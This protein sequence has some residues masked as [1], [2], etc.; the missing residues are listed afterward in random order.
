MEYEDGKDGSRGVGRNEKNRNTKDIWNIGLDVG[1][2]NLLYN[3]YT[4]QHTKCVKYY[5][6]GK[7]A[8]FSLLSNRS[9]LALCLVATFH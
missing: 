9:T 7:I 1:F 3:L 8:I 2:I 5:V 4:E 6:E